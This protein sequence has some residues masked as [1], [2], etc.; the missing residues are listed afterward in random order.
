MMVSIGFAARTGEEHV[1][2]LRRRDLGQLRRQLDGRR[3]RALEEAVV[4]R[5]LVHL[6]R[7]HVGQFPA[8][9]AHG[10][11]PQARHAVEQPPA[12][13]VV[14]IDALG[15]RDDARAAFADLLRVA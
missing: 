14:E 3:R 2:E 8:P 5:Q 6:P 1:L 11:A 15:A 10:H 13:A 4:V 12:L 7:G 9:V